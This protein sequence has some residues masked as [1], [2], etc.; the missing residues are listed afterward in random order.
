MLVFDGVKG[1]PKG[2]P[3]FWGSLTLTS[4][5]TQPTRKKRFRVTSHWSVVLVGPCTQVVARKRRKCSFRTVCHRLLREDFQNQ[6]MIC[7]FSRHQLKGYPLQ[8]HSN[9]PPVDSRNCLFGAQSP[10]RPK[11]LRPQIFP[12]RPLK[13]GSGTTWAA[14]PKPQLENLPRRKGSETPPPQGPKS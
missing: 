5:W 7:G 2:K 10:T 1:R 8:A 14:V 13:P 11:R 12:K 3:P 4:K 6:N 9:K